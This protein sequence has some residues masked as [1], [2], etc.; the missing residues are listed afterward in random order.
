MLWFVIEVA[1]KKI[2][3]E[4]I[5]LRLCVQPNDANLL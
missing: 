5:A 3:L 2:D 4:L 1:L